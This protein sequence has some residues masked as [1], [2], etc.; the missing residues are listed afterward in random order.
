MISKKDFDLLLQEI[1]R[2]ENKIVEVK[3]LNKFEKVGEYERVLEDIRVKAKNIEIADGNVVTG[4]DRV[5]LDVFS[6]L[7]SLDS[8][9]DYYIL[10]TSNV[11]ESVNDNK[12]D[13]A[14]L[15]KIRQLWE[16]VQSDVENWNSLS[17]N[18]IEEIEYNKK[19]ANRVLDI[20]CY[21]L[22]VEGILD[23][24]KVFSC[25]KREYLE[26]AI[27]ELFFEGAKNEFNDFVRKDRL[28][29]FAKNFKE[30][31]LYDYKLWLE[32]LGVKNVRAR[33]DHVEMMGSLQENER[34]QVV[35]VKFEKM[36]SSH[37]EQNLGVYDE[38]FFKGVKSWFARVAESK[39]QR[40]MNRNW[41]TAKGPAFK[42]E[43]EN[44]MVRYGNDYLDKLVV[45]NAK[46]LVVATNGVAKYN[47]EK[48]ADWRRLE[49]I[50][51]LGDKAA[52]CV[53]LSPDKTYS[54]IG[55]DSFNGCMRLK[56]V[57]LG[58]VE[59][60]GERAFKNCIALSSVVFPKSLKN[61]GDDAFCNCTGL[62][63]VT[64]LGSLQLYILDRPQNVIGCFKGSGL[65]EVV[66]PNVES[67][68]DFAIID[69]PFLKRISISG[70]SNVSVP[71]KVCKYRLGRQEGIVSF[72]CA[73]SLNLW[74][75]RNS[76][77]RFFELTEEDKEKYN[78]IKN[79]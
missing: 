19:I 54:C 34:S 24:S 63:K 44:G 61:I 49:E 30:K 8:D 18:P 15:K 60:I 40:S 22:Q 37:S 4:G 45:E 42:A 36:F 59:M 12:I 33:N 69:C 9:I 62:T 10:K 6:S 50:E 28:I 14:A 1:F 73:N 51:F 52:S 41:N 2:I 29:D 70:V 76:L 64:F 74:R 20:V 66:F 67:V 48:G 47:F 3:V 79:D 55:K 43:F 68:F 11:I 32:V 39:R 65:E 13:E 16:D 7:I 71:F 31:S 75:K 27:K 56:N 46:R 5:F 25:C 72:V 35:N 58:N 77:I 78:I 26:N 17:H 38:S 23:F 53:N 57:S 21:Q